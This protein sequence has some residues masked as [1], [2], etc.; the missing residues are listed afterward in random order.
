MIKHLGILG[1]G[2]LSSGDGDTKK[3]IAGQR[4]TPEISTH[5]FLQCTE[6]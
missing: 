2:W 4:T 5:T 6:N 1:T 3:S